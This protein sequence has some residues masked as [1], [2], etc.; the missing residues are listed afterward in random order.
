MEAALSIDAATL[1]ESAFSFVSLVWVLQ[2]VSVVNIGKNTGLLT[3]SNS[4]AALHQS[5]AP[6]ENLAFVSA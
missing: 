6:K 1:L 3:A 4:Q 2:L 5:L